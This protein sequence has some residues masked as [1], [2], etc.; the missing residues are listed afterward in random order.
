MKIMLPDST[1]ASYLPNGSLIRSSI[2]ILILSLAGLLYTCSSNSPSYTMMTYNIHR[3][4]GMDGI[5]DLHRISEVIRT[6]ETDMAILHE[7]DQGTNRSSGIFEADS[8]GTLLNMT[9]RFGRSID[10]DGGEYG[11][12]LLSN[13]PILSFQVHELETEHGFEDRTLLHALILLDSDTLHLMGTHLG[14]DTLERIDQVNRIL[15]ILPNTEKLILAGDFNFEP[16]SV[17]YGLITADLRDASL[18]K[19]ERPPPTF[20]ADKPDRR[21]DYIFI[22]DDI[23]IDPEPIIESDLTPVASDHRPQ[24]LSFKLK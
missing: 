7:V 15:S 9:S 1:V 23:E 22:G 14:L 24:V 17:P 18:E 6:S 12:S 8:L 13:Y 11:N 4:V 5:L 3:G 2:K 10:H 16:G 19:H 20:P 21:I